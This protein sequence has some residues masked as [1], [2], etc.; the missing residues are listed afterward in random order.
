MTT[1]VATKIIVTTMFSSNTM[2]NENC[3]ATCKKCNKK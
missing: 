2:A 3:T 1:E